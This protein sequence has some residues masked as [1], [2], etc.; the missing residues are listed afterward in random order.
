MWTN[1]A[2][3]EL[4]SCL[5]ATDM[6]V[7]KKAT[8]NIHNYTENVSC[9]VE[10]CTS[11]CIPFRTFRVFPNQKPWFN[12]DVRLKIRNRCAA[13]KS[14]DTT[15]YRRTRYE[16]RKSIKAAKRLYSRKLENCY[17]DNNT[18]SMWQ[19]IQAVTNYRRGTN[20]TETQ[21]NS[22]PNNLNSFYARFDRLN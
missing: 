3:T 7:F 10:W 9:Y 2:L 5:E 22:M 4:Q 6:N 20:G 12:A 16:L 11:I 19:G 17:L 15:E 18:H 21:D 13:L 1:S 14:G 8:V